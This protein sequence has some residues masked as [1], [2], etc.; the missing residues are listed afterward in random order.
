MRI[1]VALERQAKTVIVLN[2]NHVVEECFAELLEVA[3]C[4]TGG[5]DH[6]PSR[7]GTRGARGAGYRVESACKPGSV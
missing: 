4:R 6:F 2:G 1:H 5:R 7:L 3:K